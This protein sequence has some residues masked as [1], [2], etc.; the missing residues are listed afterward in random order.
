VWSHGVADGFWKDLFQG[1]NNGSISSMLGV[2]CDN[3][4]ISRFDV[5]HWVGKSSYLLLASS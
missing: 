5:E 3:R 2:K 1:V 4:A